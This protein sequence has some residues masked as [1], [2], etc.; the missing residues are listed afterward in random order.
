MR[1]YSD[2]EKRAIRQRY[3]DL[4]TGKCFCLTMMNAKAKGKITEDQ[5]DAAVKLDAHCPLHESG[6]CTNCQDQLDK[7]CIDMFQAV[8]DLGLVA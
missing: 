7:G 4:Q 2:K 1:E 6:E 5:Y 3:N 8:R